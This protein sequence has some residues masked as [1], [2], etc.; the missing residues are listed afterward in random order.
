MKDKF[1]NTNK[2]ITNLKVTK[3]LVARSLCFYMW[4]CKLLWRDRT[5]PTNVTIREAEKGFA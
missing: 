4:F 1:I 5:N 2:T 3:K